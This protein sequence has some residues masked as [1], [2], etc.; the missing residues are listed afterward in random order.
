MLRRRTLSVCL[1]LVAAAGLSSSAWGAPQLT[2]DPLGTS[3]GTSGGAGNWNTASWYGGSYDATWV[4]GDDATFNGTTGGAVTLS[5]P[6]SANNLLFNTA[7]YSITSTAASNTLTLT[8]GSVTMNTSSGTMGSVLA[9]TAG[10]TSL[11]GGGVLYLT[12]TNT[13][14][15]GVNL[16]SGTLNFVSG[17]LNG[18]LNTINCNGGILQWASGNTQD[19]SSKINITNVGQTAYLDTN[20][21]NVPFGSGISGAGALYKQGAGTLT[22][23]AIST[24]TGG[25][26]VNNGV[27]AIGITGNGTGVIRGVLT[28]NPGAKVVLTAHDVFGYSSAAVSLSTLNINGGLIDISNGNSNETYTG[29]TTNLTGGTMSGSNGYFQPFS[30]GYGNTTFNT[31]GST[32]PSVISSTLNLRQSNLNTTFTVSS[33][34]TTAGVDLLVSGSITQATAGS[35]ITKAGPGFMQATAANSYTGTTVVSAGTLQFTNASNSIGPVTVNGGLLQFTAA[36]TTGLVTVNGGTLSLDGNGG[37][38]GPIGG[39]AIT[40]NAG[41]TLRLD[42]GDASGYTSSQ[43]LTLSGG[44]LLKGVG[45][46]HDTLERPTILAG[47]T[48]TTADNGNSAS[49]GWINLFGTS[50]STSAST[51]S[52]ITPGGEGNYS[53]QLRLNS[54]NY[55]KFTLGSNSTLLIS[56]NVG[57]YDSSDPLNVTGSAGTGLMVLSGT[58]DSYSGGTNISGGLL[59][60][61]STASVP[62]TGQI[63]I[64]PNG[65]LLV[66]GAYSTVAG[67]IGAAKINT[68]STGAIVL[69]AT[70]TDSEAVNMTGYAGL[71]LGT[72]GTLTYS[73]SYTAV[74]STYNLGGGGGTLIYTP[75]IPSNSNLNLQVGTVVLTNIANSTIAALS[76]TGT[77]ATS[78]VVA[79]AAGGTQP[80]LTIGTV[81]SSF[82]GSVSDQS[83]LLQFAGAASIPAGTILIGPNGGLFVNGPYSTANAWITSGK[84]NTASTGPILLTTTGTDSQAVTMTGY[85]SLGLGTTGT[86]TY[87]GVYTPAASTYNLGGGGGALTYTP[88]IPNGSNLNVLPGTVVLTNTANGIIGALSSAGTGTINLVVNTSANGTPLTLTI[89]GSNTLTTFAGAISD[90]SLS[91]S[92]AVLSLVKTGTGTLTFSGLNGY[93]GSTTLA[94]GTLAL[95]NAGALPSGTGSITFAGGALQYS[96][97]NT[98][99]FA[100]R[101]VSSTS[102]MTIEYQRPER[103]LRRRPGR[104]QYGRL[105]QAGPGRA[106]RD[107]HGQ[108]LLRRHDP[109]RGHAANRRRGDEQRLASGQYP[110]QCHAL[111]RHPRDHD[112]WRRHHRLRQPD[113]A[114]GR[115]AGPDQHG[116]YLFHR[117]DR[118]HGD[119]A[120]R[121][122]R[123][124]QR[125]DS[126]QC[127][128]PER[129]HA[130]LRQSRGSDL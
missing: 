8:G 41:G 92:A 37:G 25:T 96:P 88:A 87:N 69:T 116:K 14:T 90:M 23:G 56:A 125:L 33:G 81:N 54:S 63:T 42:V 19:M 60:F 27:L 16:N 127:Q 104:Q 22:M 126:G 95:A 3:S 79:M 115:P 94:G 5:G 89:G 31:F 93:A 119:A 97:A 2:W 48:I 24:Y 46:F 55:P 30:N 15:G 61:A 70:G 26:I 109:Q 35:G 110:R 1:L 50:I 12:N 58:K 77:G 51:T 129:R 6:V 124:E 45:N 121:R 11:G 39:S 112:L 99:D 34:S 73:G 82:S 47:G 62:T 7:G 13:F 130:D 65:G 83:G 86:L 32:V 111:L 84:I 103:D 113:Q 59:Q 76:G 108:C 78:L 49:G 114:G 44:T 120:N 10:L 64:N 102:A 105:D 20:G 53:I 101:I 72:T 123:N 17:G 57:N 28:I 91:N 100:A 80:T 122:R 98:A 66:S 75:A 128:H 29:V 52:Y 106:Q 21:N 117:H 85:P 38:S 74:G 68:A 67:W 9:G 43:P 36:S 71:S 118:R 18:T 40:V 4:N 107:E